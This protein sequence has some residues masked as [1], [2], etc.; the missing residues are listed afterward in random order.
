MCSLPAAGRSC[1]F[2]GDNILSFIHTH[3]NYFLTTKGSKENK[4]YFALAK[5]S[6]RELIALA[7]KW[8]DNMVGVLPTI[9]TLIFSFPFFF[10]RTLSQTNAVISLDLYKISF[11]CDYCQKE[12]FFLFGQFLDDKRLPHKSHSIK[13]D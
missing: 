13:I 1:L 9:L 8:V 5:Y 3:K 7:T 2:C 12:Q 6:L 10:I 4:R 11:L